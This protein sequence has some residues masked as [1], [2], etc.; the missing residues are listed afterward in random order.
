MSRAGGDGAVLRAFGSLVGAQAR[1]LPGWCSA[2]LDELEA[3]L[4]TLAERSALLSARRAE[5]FTAGV[6]AEGVDLRTHEATMTEDGRG[7]VL[8]AKGP[9]G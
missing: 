9:R 7:Y 3:E 6:L 4:E 8:V 5:C 2:R 1:P